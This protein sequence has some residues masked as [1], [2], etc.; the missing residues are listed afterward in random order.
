MDSIAD[1]DTV[2]LVGNFDM[3]LSQDQDV[4]RMMSGLD[5]NLAIFQLKYREGAGE[6]LTRRMRIAR[7]GMKGVYIGCDRFGLWA[8][9]R[10]AT[11]DAR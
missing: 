7:A 3:I 9:C 4:I 11:R 1:R 5:I 8:E 6:A 2:L 10:W